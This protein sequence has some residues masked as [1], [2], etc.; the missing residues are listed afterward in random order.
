[1]IQATIL[2]TTNRLISI[3]W[4]RSVQACSNRHRHHPRDHP[5]AGRERVSKAHIISFCL[6][7]FSLSLTFS[8][9]YLPTNISSISSPAHD[10]I[11]GLKELTGKIFE[12]KS[13]GT[14]SHSSLFFFLF[15]ALLFTFA[16]S[17]L[18][19]PLYSAHLVFWLTR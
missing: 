19:L 12:N 4:P 10:T 18:L 9:S 8:L 17:F 7:H 6:H 14:C 5:E 1:M 11:Y 3:Y 16:V 15:F 13:E 2:P